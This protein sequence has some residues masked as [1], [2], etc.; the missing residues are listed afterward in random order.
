[1]TLEDK[2][3]DDE[4]ETIGE[5]KKI[6]QLDFDFRSEMIAELGEDTIVE[7][8]MEDEKEETEDEM[9][10]NEDEGLGDWVENDDLMEEELFPS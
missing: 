6:K 5:E 10:A 8:E 1:M 9:L 7:D 4:L 2:Y 3:E